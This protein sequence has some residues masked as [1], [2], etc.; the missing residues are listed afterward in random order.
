MKKLFL[1]VAVTVTAAMFSIA[2]ASTHGESNMEPGSKWSLG[3]GDEVQYYYLPEIDAYYY[4]PR[5]QYIYQSAGHWTFSSMLPAAYRNFDLES[6]NKIVINQAGAYRYN[7]Q[8]KAQYGAT[9]AN[10]SKK[11]KSFDADKKQLQ[12]QHKNKG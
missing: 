1:C 12:N 3:Q 10:A 6:S 7:A 5:K 4:V 11:D 9:Q 8:H 2:S